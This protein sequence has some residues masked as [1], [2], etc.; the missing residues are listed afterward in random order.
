[1]ARRPRVDLDGIA[2]TSPD[3]PHMVLAVLRYR[4]TDGL[5]LLMPESGDFDVSWAHIERAR[6]DLASGTVRIT[7]EPEWAATQNWLRGAS[8]LIGRW[9][10]RYEMK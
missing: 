9:I 5:R 8:V 2:L 1:M 3:E 7:F 6:L 10:D 4:T